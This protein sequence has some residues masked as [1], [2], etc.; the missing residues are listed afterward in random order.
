MEGAPTIAARSVSE[1]PGGS[2]DVDLARLA[3]RSRRGLLELDL[4]LGGFA[5]RQLSALTPAE[6][7]QYEALLELPDPEL[8]ELLQGRR[9]SPLGLAA[10]IRRIQ[11]T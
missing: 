4:W 5:Q 9:E 8:L 10:L 11:Q 6:R 3:W 2:E 1:A 7:R